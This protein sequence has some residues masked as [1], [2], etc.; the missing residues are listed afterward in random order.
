MSVKK[1]LENLFDLA[2]ANLTG[3]NITSS[4]A[5][6]KAFELY[7]LLAVLR[8]MRRSGFTVTAV[9]PG[10]TAANQLKFA[11]GPA[12]ADKTQ[13]T[14]FD[15]YS[16]ST[17]ERREAWVSV[18]VQTLSASI[19]AQGGAGRQNGLASYHE[20]DVAVF[21]PLPA[22]PHKPALDKLI[23]AASCKDTGFK[24]E[25]VREVLGLRRETAILTSASPSL[26]PWFIPH[27]PADP[28]VPVAL[29]SNDSQC[30]KYAQPVDSI[31]VYVRQLVF[32]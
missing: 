1:T 20:L 4:L 31:G 19:A 22:V 32:P 17:R 7:A 13:F 12:N 28:A 11:G 8:K 10:S 2:A 14:F 15:L 25:Y 29:F 5:K 18:E 21:K 30:A 6:G 9:P 23:F 24:K 27:R 3:S 26:A 16:L